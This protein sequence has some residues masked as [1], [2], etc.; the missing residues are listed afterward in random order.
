[1]TGSAQPPMTRSGLAATKDDAAQQ[2]VGL[3]DQ[4]LWGIGPGVD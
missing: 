2:R 4:D 3:A 1:M